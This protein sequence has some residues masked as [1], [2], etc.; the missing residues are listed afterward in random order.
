MSSKSMEV[1][2]GHAQVLSVEMEEGSGIFEIATKDEVVEEIL[3]PLSAYENET[4]HVLF[5]NVGLWEVSSE[6]NIAFVKIVP[7]VEYDRH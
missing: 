6:S 5:K 1:N 3:L 2:D 4:W 7:I